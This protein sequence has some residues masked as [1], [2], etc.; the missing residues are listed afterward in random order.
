MGSIC[1]FFAMPRV[2]TF[3]RT[4]NFW[5]V[6]RVYQALTLIGKDRGKQAGKAQ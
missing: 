1:I 2:D 3:D 4:A 5:A 6:G